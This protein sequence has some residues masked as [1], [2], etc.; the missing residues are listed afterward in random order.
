MQTEKTVDSCFILPILPHKIGNVRDFWDDASEKFRGDTEDQLKGVGIK[1]LLAFLQAIPDKGDFIVIYMESTDSLARTLNAMF[2]TDIEYSKYLTGQFKDFTGIDLS[3]E[4]NVPKLQLLMDWKD[5]QEYIEEK[6]MLKMPWSFTMPLKQGKTEDF[7]KLV[8]EVS[9]TRMSDVENILRHHDI[10]RSLTYLQRASQ[11]DFLV[12]HILASSPLDDL[13]ASFTTCDRE[14]CSYIR[15]MVL[16]YF[17]VDMSDPKNLP[18][19]E[20]LFKWDEAHG[21]ETAEQTIAYT[22]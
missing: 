10:V 21:F 19:V 22:E 11:G 6:N 17:G 14:M 2:A 3:K 12:R 4:E 9:R 18:H 16:E 15:K 5:S 8:G 13:I 1:R 20:L 7:L